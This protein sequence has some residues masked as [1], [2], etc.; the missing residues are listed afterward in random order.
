[1]R[2]CEMCG[3]EGLR[4]KPV[5]ANGLLIEAEQDRWLC[6]RD[7]VIRRFMIIWAWIFHLSEGVGLLAI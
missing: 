4:L 3:R 2:Q 6:T 5:K 1:M 7:R